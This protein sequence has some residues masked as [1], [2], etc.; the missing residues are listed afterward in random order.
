MDAI[1]RTTPQDPDPL[2]TPPPPAPGLKAYETPRLTARGKLATVTADL[3]TSQ[4]PP[5]DRNL[6]EGFAPVD[7]RAI[8]ARVATLPIET[9]SYRGE[10]ARHLGPMAQD[11]A[12]AFALGVDNRHI[13]PLDA[14]GVALAAIQGLHALV[15]AQEIRLQTLEHELRTLRRDIAVREAT[16]VA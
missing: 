4:L 1:E 15:R 8:L 7:P 12:A 13:F 16:P 3:P 14:S 10:A 5:S 6:K 9:W 11:F 2:V